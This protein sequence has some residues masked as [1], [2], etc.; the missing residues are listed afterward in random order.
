MLFIN[1]EK[2]QE[3]LLPTDIPSRVVFELLPNAR[4]KRQMADGKIKHVNSTYLIPMS[5]VIQ[6]PKGEAVQILYSGQKVVPFEH[7][8]IKSNFEPEPFAI[9]GDFVRD[10]KKDAE[11]IYALINS[12]FC[13]D[14]PRFKGTRHESEL[15][16]IFRIKNLKQESTMRNLD[17]AKIASA[18]AQITDKVKVSD[19]KIAKLYKAGGYK[20]A[21][22]LIENGDYETMRL[23]LSELATSDVNKF[24]EI[25]DDGLTDTRV[26]IQDAY[27]KGVV[28]LTDKG[29]VWGEKVKNVKPSQLICSIPKGKSQ[30]E[31]VEL[32][33]NFL[34]I[35][36]T[37]GV[38]DQ[39]KEEL[40]AE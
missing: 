12:P 14:N 22:I 3:V 31:A 32:F 28:S 25:F 2:P 37:T 6:D 15:R 26:V 38:Y 17:Y 27:D 5:Y 40:K 8:H 20:D 4:G 11:L 24:F 16:P 30:K 19:A 33:I 39:M 34:R 18:L 10:R 9:N 13:A 29:F 7:G 1:G 35:K 36:D 23:R 21:E